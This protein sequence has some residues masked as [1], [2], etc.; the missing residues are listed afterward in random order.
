M[1]QHTAT[2]S[3]NQRVKSVNPSHAKK[4]KA[5]PNNPTKS[6]SPG[7]VGIGRKPRRSM[8]GDTDCHIVIAI[9][10][11]K[12]TIKKIAVGKVHSIH[13][14]VSVIVVPLYTRPKANPFAIWLRTNQITIAPGTIV[15]IP[16]AASRP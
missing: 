15:S 14:R 9:S 6:R 8:E 5:L 13:S 3:M 2:A 4:M 10:I 11:R 16:A 1:I 7:V 12:M